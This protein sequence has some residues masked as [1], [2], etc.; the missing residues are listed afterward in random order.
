[1]VEVVVDV[2]VV[3]VVVVEG[4]VVEGVVDGSGVDFISSTLG[5]AAVFKGAMSPKVVWV[6]VENFVASAKAVVSS[7]ALKK[8]VFESVVAFATV[9]SIFGEDCCKTV[10]FSVEIDSPAVSSVVD[11]RP[12]TLFSDVVLA[13]DRKVVTR[14]FSRDSV[15]V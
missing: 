4:V 1:V 14:G 9:V 11:E 5:E 13:K 10:I 12:T 6:S 2:V 15:L 3:V 8:V 7:I